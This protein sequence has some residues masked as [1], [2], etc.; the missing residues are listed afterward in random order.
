MTYR[1]AE[2]YGSCK[3]YKVIGDEG[4][5]LGGAIA[6]AQNILNADNVSGVQN[7]MIVLSDG[8]A[9]NASSHGG[10]ASNECDDSVH[11]A[12]NAAATVTW[13][14]SIAYGSST[15]A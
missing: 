13:V 5:Y 3:G 7:V 1:Q 9:G 6:T 10:P 2:L 12:G 14:Y 15:A 4:T 11:V 8:G